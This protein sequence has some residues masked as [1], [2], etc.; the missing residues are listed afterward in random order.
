MFHQHF[1]GCLCV[2]RPG[3]EINGGSMNK[4]NQNNPNCSKNATKCFLGPNYI[5]LI[6]RDPILKFRFFSNLQS[7]T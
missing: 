4:I 1:R 6:E 7:N 3:L 5:L 2:C